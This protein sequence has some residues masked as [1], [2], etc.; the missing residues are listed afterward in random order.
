MV[1]E[2]YNIQQTEDAQFL[3]ARKQEL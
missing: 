1:L 3:D 2:A